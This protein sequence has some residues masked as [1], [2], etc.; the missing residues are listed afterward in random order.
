MGMDYNPTLHFDGIVVERADGGVDW[1]RVLYEISRTALPRTSLTYK[2][3]DDAVV[4]IDDDL[5]EV[6]RVP[7]WR[8]A[9]F[10]DNRLTPYIH[11]TLNQIPNREEIVAT[12]AVC[13]A[14]VIDD[15]DSNHVFV[16][17]NGFKLT[18]VHRGL[19]V[20]GWPMDD[21]GRFDA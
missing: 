14:D 20:E 16:H 10:D 12:L 13:G 6:A 5:G 17:A 21:D 11:D 19:L 15:P 4:A 7:L 2:R 9:C 18:A 1:R 8:V 3:L